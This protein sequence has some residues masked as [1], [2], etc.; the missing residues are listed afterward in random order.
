MANILV[1][2]RL[3][4]FQ[5]LQEIRAIP[6]TPIGKE[7]GFASG[8]I[9]TVNHKESNYKE[10][11]LPNEKRKPN[12]ERIVWV[13]I[14]GIPLSVWSHATFSRI[15]KKWG[16]VMDIEESTGSSFARK[17]LCIKT[18]LADNILESFI[19]IFKGKRYRVR[20][21]ELFTW[22]TCFL[23]YK[24]TKYFDDEDSIRGVNDKLAESP[25][26]EDVL[27]GESDVEGVSDMIFRDDSP[28]PINVSQQEKQN[29]DVV[30]V[31]E[32]CYVSPI[33]NENSRAAQSKA[34]DPCIGES[35][36]EFSTSVHSRKS[37]N[38]G[39]IL[40]VLDG[41][42]KVGQS[43]GY[44]MEGCSKDIE[45]IIG[46]QGD[47]ETK[48]DC[49]SNMDVKFMWGNSNF[50]FVTSDS[51]VVIYSPQSVVLK[52]TLWEY[53]LVLINRWNGETLVLGD[54]N[55]VRSEDER[56]GSIFSPSSAQTFN[57]F[58]A[59]SGLLDV[60]MEGYSFT[61]SHP[62]ASKMSKLDWFLVSDEEAPRLEE[63]IPVWI[64]D[65]NILKE[66]V[67]S[68]LTDKL[69]D[70]DKELDNCVISDDMFLNSLELS[71][72]LYELNQSDLKDVAQKAKVKWVIEGDEN[73][74][75]LHGI[76]N[77]RRAQLAI[78]G[79]FDSGV[80]LTD[81]PLM[82][83]SFLNHFATR[84]KQPASS[85]LKLNMSFPN[86][87]TFD[88]IDDLD[89]I[90]TR[91]E[92]KAANR[93][94]LDGL[95]ILNE[96]LA[97]CKRKKKQ[98]LMFKV[99]FAKAY[100]SV[101]WD[102]L[103]DALHAF[104]FGSR[105]CSWIRG[106]FSSNM[107]SILVNGSPTSE[108]LISCGLKQGDPLA[109]LLFIL[110]MKTLHISVSR[111]V[112]D[113]V[114]KGEWSDD[115]LANL[116]LQVCDH[117]FRHS[118][119]S[120]IIQ[121]IHSRLSMWKAKTLSIGGRLTLLKSVLGAVSLYTMSIYKAPKGVL[122]EMEM[123]RNKFF[124][125]ADS[126]VR[127]INWVAWDKVLASKKHRGLGVSSYYAFNRALLL[128]WVW[129]FIS[130]DSSLWSRVINAIYGSS[131]E[132]H[133]PNFS[134]CWNSILR[135]VHTLASKGFNFLSHC[136]I[137]V[138]NGINTR[139]WLDTW[140]SDLPLSIRFPSIFALDRT[141][142]VSVAVKRGASSLNVS[143]RRQVRDGIESHQ[144]SKL[145]LLLGS[146]IFSPSSDRWSC[147]L[148]G[149]GM[150]DV[151]DIRSVL[152]DLFLPSSIEATRWA[153][154]V[155]IKVNVFAWR[156]RLDRLPTRDN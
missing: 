65:M 146:F 9:L 32:D 80:W 60:K 13:D 59:S 95:F 76:I 93:R 156:A 48:M 154:Y 137:R 7:C 145:N 143:F 89:R 77:K 57:H 17:R 149:E 69:V 94:I 138:G 73:S 29:D 108:F 71:R 121:K 110:V 39:S 49:I 92:I 58:I 2:D 46:F 153:K 82:K 81:S 52:H 26:D 37:L 16:D 74:K 61:W 41:I 90:I 114:F 83:N 116:E 136:K 36:C 33:Q 107:A 85:R 103:L 47:V 129:R 67:K 140:I 66:G 127:K 125:G 141:K 64:R 105:W 72:K 98:A 15:G 30:H 38:G 10:P 45:R 148:N 109:P 68:S 43:M 123:I 130:Q 86:R 100:D 147:D 53:I 1:K 117:M 51:V 126:T 139:F 31:R 23:E 5:E 35:S 151:K 28:S 134:S 106:I 133:A 84:F 22:T 56:F 75:F 150:F 4:T 79:V 55:E 97:W 144:W 14:E 122:H 78:R 102:F 54:F 25:L 135:E 87:L 88:Q 112:H 118:A 21:K 99:D 62:S 155:P 119:W 152:D 115:N 42:I 50:Q 131:I 11:K 113:G 70:I 40:D 128:K 101:R 96:A 132:Y 19:V 44:D 27:A 12:N 24:D 8:D 142:A 3:F 104:G 111:S 91:D 124:I 120:T 34:M 63:F 18:C 20:A 6:T